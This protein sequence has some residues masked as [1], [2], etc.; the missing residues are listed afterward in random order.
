ME[1]FGRLFKNKLKIYCYPLLDT[2]TGHL[3]TCDNLEIKGELKNLYAYLKDCGGITP[4]ENFDADCLG[5]FSREVLGKIKVG[6]SSW[7]S[8]VPGSVAD[9]IKNK[10]YFDYQSSP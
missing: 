5:I 1:S 9:V 4:L 6:D 3:T 2:A 7:E 10:N 8:M